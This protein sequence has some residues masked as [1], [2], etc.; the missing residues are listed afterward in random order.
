[1]NKKYFKIKLFVITLHLKVLLMNK[2]KDDIQL[3]REMMERSSSFLSLSGLS[4][5][6]AG[7]VALL[8]S[9]IAWYMMDQHH[10]DYFDENRNEFPV[11]IT[12]QLVFIAIMALVCAF[13]FGF[14]FTYSKSKRL[15]IPLWNK[16][17]Q[18]FLTQLFIPL[19]AGGI[20]CLILMKYGLFF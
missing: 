18:Y 11:E 10:V 20:L 9:G 13:L 16:T 6:A 17:T 5:V 2:A 19:F 7:T 14:Y 1:M 4:G 3:I 8:A 12:K 15:Q